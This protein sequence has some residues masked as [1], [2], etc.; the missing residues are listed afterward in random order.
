[1]AHQHQPVMWYPCMS[2]PEAK[3]RVEIIRR[4]VR[5]GMKKKDVAKH[6]GVTPVAVGR[7]VRGERIPDETLWG[8]IDQLAAGVDMETRDTQNPYTATPRTIRNTPELRSR[9]LGAM[10]DHDWSFGQ[11]AKASGYDSPNTIRRLLVDGSIDFFP[12]ML[13]AVAKALDVDLDDLPMSDTDKATIHALAPAMPHAYQVRDIPVVAAANAAEL[14]VVN[15][16]LE[17][18]DWESAE[19]IPNPTDGRRCVAFRVHGRSMF[20]TLD[21]GDTVVVDCD[22]PPVPGK[23]AV[24]ILE[25][26]SILV[27]VWRPLGSDRVLLQSLNTDGEDREVA[28]S[29]IRWAKRAIRKEGV[30]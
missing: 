11:L 24:C 23:I 9:L 4:V 7:Y 28:L 21:D 30:L 15:G 27:K 6:L 17:F 29:E 13:A 22:Q 8:R 12:V 10:A 18:D 2:S 26:D 1:M 3:R 5:A 25:D 16:I 14:S 20:P 19:K